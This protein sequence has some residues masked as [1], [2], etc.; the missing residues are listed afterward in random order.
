V[1]HP[2]RAEIAA[3]AQALGVPAPDLWQGG[4]DP[5]RVDLMPS[6][7]GRPAFVLG[8]G[9]LA[10]LLPAQ[11]F[12]LA[13]L[14]FGLRLGIAPLLRRDPS[15]AATVLFAAAAAAE[16]PLAA[17][18][19]RAGMAETTRKLQKAMPR[20]VR[21]VVPDHARALGD[22]REILSWTTLIHRTA[23]RAGLLLAGDLGSALREVLGEAP[24]RELLP[25]APDAL[26]LYVFGLSPG[27]IALRRRLGL[28]T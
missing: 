6:Y 17:G 1:N 12:V 14:L 23:S 11:R 7:K 18:E 26:D 16:A 10:P 15:R 19:G 2:L 4:D 5:S 22:G 28:S 21:K 3:L 13:R 25:G 9:V 24:D 8:A 27:A 20:K